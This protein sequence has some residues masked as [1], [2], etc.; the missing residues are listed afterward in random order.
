MCG[1]GSYQ[2]EY[3]VQHVYTSIE[4]RLQY[5]HSHENPEVPNGNI[6]KP[7]QVS[8]QS[9]FIY[10]FQHM[11]SNLNILLGFL[12][13]INLYYTMKKI[14]KLYTCKDIKSYLLKQLN[15]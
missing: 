5:T 3:A 10:S 13:K 4:A 11:R 7:E 2:E 14:Q 15:Q 12:L 9:S 1:S 8:N 6:Y